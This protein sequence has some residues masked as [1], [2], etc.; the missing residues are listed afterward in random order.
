MKIFDSNMSNIFV[1]L[2]A[3]IFEE[4]FAQIQRIAYRRPFDECMTL[5][6]TIIDGA[7]RRY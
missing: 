5:A 1:L 3:N 7:M 2:P 4:E 6:E